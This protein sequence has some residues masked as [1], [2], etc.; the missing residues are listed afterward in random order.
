MYYC[1]YYSAHYFLK[2]EERD[3][4]QT[5]CKWRELPGKAFDPT[6]N[7]YIIVQ[8]DKNCSK[9]VVVD[10]ATQQRNYE[11]ALKKGLVKKKGYV[12]ARVVEPNMFEFNQD[13][14]YYNKMIQDGY[15]NIMHSTSL[16]F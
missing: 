8:P 12:E 3:G 4:H 11:Y 13:P 16:L 15:Q 9:S 10:G 7:G 2:K 6:F 14:N 1:Q 5:V